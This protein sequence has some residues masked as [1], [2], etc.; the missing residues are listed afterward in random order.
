[1]A[2]KRLVMVIDTKRCIGC[3]TCSMACKVENNLPDGVWWNRTLTVG[4]KDMDTPSG[5][6][7]DTKLQYLT[8]AC[9]HCEKPPCVDVCPEN[10]T[11]KREE[12]GVV[13]QDNDLCTG[14]GACV[15]ACP[16]DGVRLLYSDD[17]RYRLDFA[18]GARDAPAH[19]KDTIGKCTFCVHRLAEGKVPFCIDV[20]PTRAR[21]FGDKNDPDS[22]VS[23]LLKER[24]HFQY[25]QAKGTEPSIFFLK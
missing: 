24:P 21:F 1:M 13:I 15:T 5:V 9:Q 19:R 20:C 23:L 12:D 16:Y 22:T 8:L 4:G 17:P 2:N 6:F 18:V 11:F 14:C 3:H 10:A 25:L 7:P